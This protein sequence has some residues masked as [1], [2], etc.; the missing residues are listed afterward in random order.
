MG[1]YENGVVQNLWY[2]KI[3]FC[4]KKEFVSKYNLFF[5]KELV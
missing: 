2:E 3:I 1:F 5:E 4:P